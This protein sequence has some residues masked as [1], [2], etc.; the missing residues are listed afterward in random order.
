MSGSDNLVPRPKGS[1]IA[2]VTGA[3]GFLGAAVACAFRDAGWKVAGFD[4]ALGGPDGMAFWARGAV[5]R[6]TLAEAA[7]VIG[8]P[9]VVFHAA[10]GSSVG[11]S[12]ADPEADFA[13]TVGS[14]RETLA[15]LHR[16][17]SGARLI[18]PS[19]AAV[20]GAGSTG[21]I[22]ETA[23]LQPISPYGVHKVEAEMTIGAAVAGF[24]LDVVILRFFSLYGPGLRKQILWDLARR[25]GAGEQ[26]LGLS[27][28]GYEARDFLFIDDAVVLIGL[29]AGLD[30]AKAHRTLNA[31][32]GEATT[33]RT[34]AES[35]VRALGSD[36]VVS[37]SGQV[38]SGD[39]ASLV[40]DVSEARALG[41]APKVAFE[42]GVKSFARWFQALPAQGLA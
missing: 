1:G 27:G 25:L 18:Y 8:P 14:L 9:E 22:S 13:R 5:D 6:K 30:P 10:G 42:D 19:S 12:I 35:L 29:A 23:A 40:A 11:A 3:A 17:G 31:G 41:F 37:F 36:A 39:P 38:R 20:Y 34:V 26:R 4:P 15:F 2:F 7:R 33:V 21:P 32:R 16:D 24:G 28:Q